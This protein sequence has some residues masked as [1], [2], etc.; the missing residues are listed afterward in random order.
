MKKQDITTILFT[1]F[2]GAMAGAYLFLVGFKPQVVQVTAE[3]TPPP[4]PAKVITIEGQQYGGCER[5]GRCASFRI[6]DNGEYSYLATSVPTATGPYGG[7]L[8]RR[9]WQQIRSRLSERVLSA[10]AQ[11]VEPEVCGSQYDLVDYQYEILYQGTSYR[12]DTC[13][14]ALDRESELGVTLDWLWQ[15]MADDIVDL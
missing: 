15:F 11:S 6:K 3:L 14:T 5:S 1:F 4:D 2:C 8:A 10:S 13:G 7:A 12:L 9:D